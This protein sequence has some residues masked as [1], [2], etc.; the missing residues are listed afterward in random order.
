[1]PFSEFGKFLWGYLPWSTNWIESAN[2][3]MKNP[4]I[5]RF[6]I[7]SDVS[8]GVL[9]PGIIDPTIVFP[10]EYPYTSGTTKIL[11]DNFVELSRECRS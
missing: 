11:R 5:Q 3:P 4:I 1:M 2:C 9:G 10:K 6:V 7:L 8:L